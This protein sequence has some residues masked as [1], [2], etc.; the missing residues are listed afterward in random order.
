MDSYQKKQTVIELTS[1]ILHKHYCENDSG[2]VTA[3]FDDPFSWFGAGEQEYA[4]GKEA[5]TEIF[6]QFHGMVPKCNISDEEYDVIEI[7]PDVFL[8]SGRLWIT[9]DPS[10]NMYLQVHQRITTVFHWVRDTARCSHI[11]ISNPYTEMS[12]SE[13]GFPSQMG[14]QSY[15]YLQKCILEQ[16]RKIQEQTAMLERMSYEDSMTGLYNRNKFDQ[17]ADHYDGNQKTRLG[18]ACFDLN[19][20]KAINDRQGHSAG[21]DLLCRTAGHLKQSFD[22]KSYRIG[23]D[24]FVVIDEDSSE[25]EFYAA[26]SSTREG[27][28]Q[29]RISISI[30]SCWRSSQCSIREQFDTADRRMYEEKV[31]YYSEHG[32]DRRK[33]RN[34]L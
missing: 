9:T 6:C 33:N 24:E 28:K 23:G 4:V 19:G 25:E 12:S 16:E 31:R 13:I 7:T 26:I 1:Y 3:L 5:V 8:C 14:Q 21:D 10:T 15:D 34:R 17:K 20:L 11:H 2:A 30:G 27:M 18:V 32:H 22:K 29:D